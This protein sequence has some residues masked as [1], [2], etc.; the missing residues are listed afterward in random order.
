MKILPEK[1]GSCVMRQDQ[2]LLMGQY[3]SLNICQG[4]SPVTRQ[5][6]RQGFSACSGR[7][8]RATERQSPRATTTEPVLQSPGAAPPEASRL[9]SALRKREAAAMR[10]PHATRG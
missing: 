8:P 7:F 2:C 10:S 9:E 5:C 4:A 3:I 6:R 1:G